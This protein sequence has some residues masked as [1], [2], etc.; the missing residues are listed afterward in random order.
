[1]TLLL[2]PRGR[3][4]MIGRSTGYGLAK[5]GEDPVNMLRL[6]NAYRAVTADLL[7][8]LGLSASRR[9]EVRLT[10]EASVTAWPP[11]RIDH[12][13]RADSFVARSDLHPRAR[14]ARTSVCD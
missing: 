6:G 8:L 11:R 13:P 5:Q 2:Y 14:S 3:P 7:K 4:L 12:K 10:A 1:M 9:M